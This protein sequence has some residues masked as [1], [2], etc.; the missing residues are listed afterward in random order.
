MKRFGY[1][2]ILIIIVIGFVAFRIQN[3]SADKAHSTVIDSVA[4]NETKKASLEIAS[5]I[6]EYDSLISSE[7][8]NSGTVGS[9]LVII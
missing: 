7:I 3:V 8:I 5:V 2:L 9:A 6:Q 1:L 4:L